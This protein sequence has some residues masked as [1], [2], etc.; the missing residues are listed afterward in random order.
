MLLMWSEFELDF[1]SSPIISF[2]NHFSAA[3]LNAPSISMYFYL[4]AYP[5]RRIGWRSSAP[6]FIVTIFGHFIFSVL[7]HSLGS[8]FTYVALLQNR[9]NIDKE[10]PVTMFSVESVNN[11]SLST[12]STK[13]LGQP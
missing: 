9:M 12:S 4:F 2:L 1:L 6:L 5:C 8:P 7:S 13:P 11:R 3:E 10:T